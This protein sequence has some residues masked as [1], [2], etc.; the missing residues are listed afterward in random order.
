MVDL[1]IGDRM[2]KGFTLIELL[3]VIILL[4]V[5]ALIAYPVV[6]SS[7]KNSREKAYNQTINNI[8]ESARIY[9]TDHKLGYDSELSILSFETLQQAGYLENEDII[10]PTNKKPIEG[11]IMYRWNEDKKQYEYNFETNCIV[12]TDESCFEYN[13][14]SN[15]TVEITGYDT[16]CGR[17]VILPRKI[18]EKNISS[19]ARYSFSRSSLTSIDFSQAIDLV[20]IEERALEGN[21]LSEVNFNNLS[22]LNSVG[23]FGFSNN[24]LSTIDLSDLVSLEYIDRYA[25]SDNYLTNVIFSSSV[26]EI[27]GGAFMNNRLSS[28]TIPDNIMIINWEAFSNNQLTSVVLS[29]NI[30][31]IGSKAFYKSSIS[32]PNLTMIANKSGKVFNWGSIINGLYNSQYEFNKGTVVNG[33]GNVEITN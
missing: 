3:G 20:Q 16:S 19:L 7:I 23:Y 14:L 26:K 29:S 13:V 6:D 24:N 31:E 30:S 15:N 33:A 10:N 18:G 17:N 5:L 8:L 25:F 21:Y 2:K 32:N 11:C 12:P 4:G 9:G 22:K 1:I 28:I 27:E